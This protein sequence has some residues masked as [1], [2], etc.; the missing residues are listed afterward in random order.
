MMKEFAQKRGLKLA[1]VAALVVAAGAAL[2]ACGPSPEE[3]YA[4][5]VQA[6]LTKVAGAF[7]DVATLFDEFGKDDTKWDDPVWLGKL[8]AAA[9]IVKQ[10]HK[11][12]KALPAPDSMKDI[13]AQ[14]ISAT[15][16]CSDAMDKLNAAVNEKNVDGMNEA[17]TLGQS[18]SSKM[19]TLNQQL[20]KK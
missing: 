9:D 5:E 2:A 13:H 12:L 11:A 3:T 6:Q 18:C 10:S 15:Q 7:G 19:D 1:L 8:K 4:T 16:D 17:V 20:T 14:L